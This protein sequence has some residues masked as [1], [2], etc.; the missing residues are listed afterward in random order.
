MERH[1]ELRLV[2]SLFIDVVGSTD[3]AVRLG[4]E[5][6]Q[7]LLADAFGEL[8]ATITAHG[9]VVEKYI[10]DAILG[11]FGIP[12]SRLDDA[13][14]ALRAADAAARWA[15][16]WARSGGLEIRAGLEIGDLLV[17]PKQLE[18]SQRMVIGE[19]INLA[20]R[21]QSHAEP[22]QIVVGPRF[23]EATADVATFDPLGG[24]ELKGFGTV[25]AWR[26]KGFR[27]AGVAAELEFVGRA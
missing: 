27:D 20:A 21:L 15:S 9:G 10:G 6:M 23:H 13:E 16:A 17:D 25:D 2:T 12:I 18:T 11:T 5:R 3:A 19:S 8:S 26:F 7:R 24:L 22:G 4:P 14:R 1:S